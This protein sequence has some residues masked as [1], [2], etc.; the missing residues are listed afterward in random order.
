MFKRLLI[1]LE[2]GLPAALMTCFEWWIFE[3]LAILAGLISVEALAAE[4]II[5]TIVS[6]MFMIP[7]GCSFAASAFTGF[8]CA[9]GKIKEAKKYTRLTVAF[10][11]LI[12]LLVLGVIFLFENKISHFFTSDE[13]VVQIVSDSFK[14][15]Y[16]YISF[17]SIHGTNSGIIRGLGRTTMAALVTFSCYWIIGLGGAIYLGFTKQ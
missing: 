14:V 2:L 7:L 16:L 10:G 3:I 6:F 15:L 9:S 13:K 8:F 17:D 1:Y 12:T 4:V 5:V 11:E